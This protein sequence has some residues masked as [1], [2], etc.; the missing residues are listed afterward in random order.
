M[1]GIK[2]FKINTIKFITYLFEGFRGDNSS[3]LVHYNTKYP[4]KKLSDEEKEALSDLLQK[5]NNN[6]KF[7]N[8]VFASLQILMNEIV[9]ENYNSEHLI[10]KIIENLPKFIILNQTLVKFF[11][12]KYEYYMEEKIFTINTLVSIFEYF[13]ALCWDDIK[14]DVLEDYK[15]EISFESKQYILNYFKENKNEKTLINKM[16]F[17][18]ALRK[19]ISRSIAGSRQEIEN[20]SKAKLKLYIDQYQLWDQEIVEKELFQPEILKIVKD[21]LIVDTVR[22]YLNC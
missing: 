19:L 14:K 9:K 10:Y 7:Y 4:S 20:E 6:N 8:D 17:T 22:N 15:I 1:P 12:D 18:S 21:D 13:E 11:K 2:I 3:I 5:N 16:N